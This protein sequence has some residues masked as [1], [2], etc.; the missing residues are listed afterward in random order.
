MFHISN[1]A[2]FNVT[3]PEATTLCDRPPNSVASLS[4][5]TPSCNYKLITKLYNVI[6]W[7]IDAVGGRGFY[8]ISY[9]FG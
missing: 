4:H 1:L 7:N 8:F 5:V 2:F 3:T 9:F 6:Q